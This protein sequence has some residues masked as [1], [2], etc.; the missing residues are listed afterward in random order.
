MGDGLSFCHVISS[1]QRLVVTN[2]ERLTR[3]SL[4]IVSRYMCELR[5][6]LRVAIKD[7]D[8]YHQQ[9]LIWTMSSHQNIFGQTLSAEDQFV[10][11]TPSQ[12]YSLSL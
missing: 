3:G 8:F 9:S 12:L 10:N 11:S 5:N 2:K 7:S 4:F 1:S 6:L